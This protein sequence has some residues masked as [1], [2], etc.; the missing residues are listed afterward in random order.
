MG[1]SFMYARVSVVKK[2]IVSIGE[3]MEKLGPSVICYWWECQVMHF[4]KKQKIY[5]KSQSMMMQ[6]LWKPVRQ[7]L[8]KLNIKLPRDSAVLLLPV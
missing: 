1:C 6:S 8:K 4:G 3:D 7:F 5:L 2:T